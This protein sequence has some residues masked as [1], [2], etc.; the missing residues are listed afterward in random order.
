[1]EHPDEI[2]YRSKLDL[3]YDSFLTKKIYRCEECG[4]IYY[5]SSVQSHTCTSR[6]AVITEEI[7]T[8][9]LVNGES[10]E[11]NRLNQLL[12]IKPVMGSLWFYD[13]IYMI[14]KK[15]GFNRHEKPKLKDDIMKP[16]HNTLQINENAQKEKFSFSPYDNFF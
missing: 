16:V 4:D 5:T 9:A 11:M 12:G 7:N 14:W 2:K 15:N 10:F 1:M 3:D 6:K 8:Q 13:E